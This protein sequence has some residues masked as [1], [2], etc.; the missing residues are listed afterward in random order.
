MIKIKR[1]SKIS[2]FS[3]KW[4]CVNGCDGIGAKFLWGNVQMTK[5]VHSTFFRYLGTLFDLGMGARVVVI[6]ANSLAIQQAASSAVDSSLIHP[7]S[8]SINLLV[9]LELTICT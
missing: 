3:L 4:R 7:T 1:L 6:P 5:W 8:Q 9:G 2:L